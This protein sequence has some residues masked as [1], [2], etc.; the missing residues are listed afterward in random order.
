MQ[1]LRLLI[2]IVAWSSLA[3]GLVLDG[4]LLGGKDP[5]EAAPIAL[6]E[7]LLAA[8]ELPAEIE[9]QAAGTYPLRLGLLVRDREIERI[10]DP[11]L[12]PD[13]ARAGRVELR[14]TRGEAE[15]ERWT[16]AA[17]DLAVTDSV[18]KEKLSLL[19]LARTELESPGPG[20]ARIEVVAEGQQ[21]G[22]LLDRSLGHLA[23]LL[24]EASEVLRPY[25]ARRILPGLLILGG[26]AGAFAQAFM[27]LGRLVVPF[28]A[29]ALPDESF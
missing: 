23:L 21:D 25:V 8:R 11:W 9:F 14:I 27:L 12:K 16:V 17:A 6:P 26:L 10:G 3:T 29:D 2:V 5:K 24:G 13:P 20:P 4:R 19:V 18:L 1:L 22:D 7:T 15:P 28:R